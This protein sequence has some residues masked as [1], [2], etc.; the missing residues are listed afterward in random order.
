MTIQ[1]TYLINRKH[2][3]GIYV[4]AMGYAITLMEI[5]RVF[6][7][8][9]RNAELTF[10][11]RNRDAYQ[12]A[13]RY[14]LVKGIMSIDK[15]E[16]SIKAICNAIE[17]LVG[18]CDPGEEIVIYYNDIPML[19]KLLLKQNYP[20]KL[21]SVQIAP[22]DSITLI[23]CLLTDRVLTISNKS[24]LLNR[25]RQALVDYIDPLQVN[26][27]LFALALNLESFVYGDAG[28]VKSLGNIE[29]A[30]SA[31]DYGKQIQG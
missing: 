13:E 20:A 7:P 15:S 26:H 16:L 10:L 28:W 2:S 29:K 25:Y 24:E 8:I 1:Q 17:V 22:L 30:I 21:Q 31:I 9:E 12:E 3:I 18:S 27:A 14:R 4:D 5:N 6:I 23:N 19:E 11:E